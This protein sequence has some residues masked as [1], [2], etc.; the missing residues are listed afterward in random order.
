MEV[1]DEE[2]EPFA[3]RAKLEV[4]PKLEQP[5]EDDEEEGKKS[6][7]DDVNRSSST[8]EEETSVEQKVWPIFETRLLWIADLFIWY[9]IQVSEEVWREDSS[10]VVDEASREAQQ[11]EAPSQP[12]PSSPSAVVLTES[13]IPEP[14]ATT[15]TT[16]EA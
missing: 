8:N 2:E 16:T 9:V 3:K 12:A 6:E 14:P 10:E 11:P 1:E 5:K 13:A 15:T 7:M 4:E